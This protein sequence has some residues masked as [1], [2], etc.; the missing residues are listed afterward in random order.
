LLSRVLRDD[1]RLEVLRQCIEVLRQVW[2]MNYFHRSGL[3]E[4]LQEE[5][6][7][8]WRYWDHRPHPKFGEKPEWKE[9]V[10]EELTQRLG[11]NA[12]EIFEAL[13]DAGWITS[14]YDGNLSICSDRIWKDHVIKMLA[15]LVGRK[16]ADVRESFEAL[17]NV[18]QIEYDGTRIN[19]NDDGI[20]V[21][22]VLKKQ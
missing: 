21:K 7:N 5:R 9:H 22:L 10:I 8:W 11:A 2:D 4:V 15:R 3:R 12:R 19:W 20:M 13:L 14:D 17:F 1:P 18:G 16:E 6:N